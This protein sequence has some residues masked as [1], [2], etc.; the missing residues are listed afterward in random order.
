MKN[1]IFNELIPE[2]CTWNFDEKSCTAA[3]AKTAADLRISGA[4]RTEAKQHL[5]THK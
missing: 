5:E 3:V 2:T 1:K 4:Q